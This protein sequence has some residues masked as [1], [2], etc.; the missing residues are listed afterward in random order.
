MGLL[1]IVYFM[2]VSLLLSEQLKYIWI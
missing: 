1:R 2:Y